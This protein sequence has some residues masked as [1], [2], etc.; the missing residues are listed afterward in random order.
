MSKLLHDITLK[1][2]GGKTE[3]AIDGMKI[4]GLANVKFEVP[5]AGDNAVITL[6][7]YVGTLNAD[8][9]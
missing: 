1:Q 6:S 4:K 7:V 9:Q 2:F 8:N 5:S 3:V